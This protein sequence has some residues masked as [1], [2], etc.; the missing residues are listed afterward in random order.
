MGDFG[1]FEN[2]PFEN[3]GAAEADDAID[4]VPRMKLSGKNANGSANQ[5][6][7]LRFRV[8]ACRETG[9]TNAFHRFAN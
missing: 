5:G 6:I 7:T 2:P 3:A 4:A 8:D 9:F 1:E